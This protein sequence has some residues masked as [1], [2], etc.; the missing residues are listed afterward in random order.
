VNGVSLLIGPG[1]WKYPV[2]K[3]KEIDQFLD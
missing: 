1:A 3:I 2:V